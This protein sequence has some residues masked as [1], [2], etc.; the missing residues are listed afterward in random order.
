MLL[1]YN[2]LILGEPHVAK[3]RYNLY[4]TGGD[5]IRYPAFPEM[6]EMD[7]DAKTTGDG[8]NFVLERAGTSVDR[9]R[10]DAHGKPAK[11]VLISIVPTLDSGEKLQPQTVVVEPAEPTS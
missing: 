7:V 10:Q 4:L 8:Q 5:I 11:E 2:K 9:F 6:Q 3:L 1:S